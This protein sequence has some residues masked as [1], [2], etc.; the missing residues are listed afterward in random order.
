MKPKKSLGQNFLIDKNILKKIVNSVN[1]KGENILFFFDAASTTFRNDI[2]KDYKANRTDPPDELIPQ[3]TLIREATK[4][5]GLKY[6]EVENYEADD[7]IA[8]YAKM[9]KTENIE[10]VIISS[11]KDLM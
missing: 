7:I 1:I 10:T 3:F 2:Y 4:A 11:D 8:T 6:L 5:L 9:A